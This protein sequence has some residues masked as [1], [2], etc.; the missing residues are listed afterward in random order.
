MEKIF[1]NI[2]ALLEA[3]LK[4]TI[5]DLLENAAEPSRLHFSVVVQDEES[6]EQ[7][8]RELIK[9]YGATLTYKFIPLEKVRGI[10]YARSLAQEPLSLDYEYY[11]QLDAHSRSNEEWDNRLIQW[12]NTD[13]WDVDGKFIYSTYPKVYGYVNDL[14]SDVD[15]ASLI[16]DKG[17]SIYYENEIGLD[18]TKYNKAM[19]QLGKKLDENGHGYE[20]K[21]VPWVK[22]IKKRNH[23]LFCAGFAFGRTEHFLDVPYDPNFFYT[24][25]ELSMAYRF[26]SKN[27]KIIEPYENLFYH[28]YYGHKN[29]R[30]PSWYV[31]QGDDFSEQKA[32]INFYELEDQSRKRLELFTDGY[33]DEPFGIT[34]ETAKRFQE[35]H[36]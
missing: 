6:Q 14:G 7:W 13:G 18:G 32:K 15:I 5:K 11:L 30:R 23:Q 8:L 19:L 20:V 12:H 28:D 31:E 17:Q 35:V 21:R 25:E 9:F 24:G 36:F 10:G 3:E 4:P 33:L 1:I 16:T 29:G 2:V 22:D 34:R 26:F 27:V